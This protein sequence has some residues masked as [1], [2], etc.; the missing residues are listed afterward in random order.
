MAEEKKAAKA[1]KKKGK[2]RVCPECNAYIQAS[3]N[4]TIVTLTEP[5]G[6]T[7]AWASSGSSGFKGTRKATPY[8]AQITAENAVEKAKPVGI[9]K[10]NVFVKGVGPGREQAIRGLNASGL[11]IIAITDVT[12]IPHNGCRPKKQRRN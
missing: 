3:Y 5:T 4:N 2:K 7:I 12:P 6:D 10:V 9:E 11:Q 1:P 8:A